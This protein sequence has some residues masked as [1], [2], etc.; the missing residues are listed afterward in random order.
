M[1]LTD[2]ELVYENGVAVAIR[3]AERLIS[4]NII[5]EFMLAA[6]VAVSRVLRE[7]EVPT[8]Y[9]IHEEISPDS[10]I[11]LKNFLKQLRIPFKATG[12]IGIRIQE[13]L[14]HVCG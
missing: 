1:H 11:K 9:R 2:S 7:R 6:N 8:L 14:A 5:E 4:N 10:L 12:D 3:Y 13:V